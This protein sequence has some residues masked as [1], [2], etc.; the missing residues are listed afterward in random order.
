M[1]TYVRTFFFALGHSCN[2]FFLETIFGRIDKSELEGNRFETFIMEVLKMKVCV[3]PD[4]FILSK[5]WNIWNWFDF[6]YPMRNRW[7]KN[8]ENQSIIKL[9]LFSIFF[10]TKIVHYFILKICSGNMTE[11]NGY[12]TVFLNYLL[13]LITNYFC[14]L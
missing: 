12:W 4:L 14:F 9:Q 10:E 6:F 2:Y 3:C 8:V 11:G 1:Q 7:G 13:H 5:D